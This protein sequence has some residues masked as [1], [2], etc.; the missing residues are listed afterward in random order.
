M[1]IVVAIKQVPER[2]APIHIASDGKWIDDAD[3]NYTINEPDAYALEEALQ[4]KERNGSGEVIVVCAGPERVQSTLREAL[5]KGADRA[6]HIEAD[7][8]TGLDTLGIAQILAD[9][10]KPESPDLILTGLQSDDLGLGQTGVVLAEVLNIPHAT[11]IMHVEP[12]GSGLKV[13]REL[14]DGWF[15]HVEM[16]LPALLTIQSGGNKL[17]YATLMGIKKAKTKELKTV[18]ASATSATPAITLERVYLP[19]KQK[20][21]EMLTGS[22]A[23]VA[24]KIVEKLKF[25]VRVI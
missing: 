5:A 21:T 17:R 4:L 7:D 13:K 2:D 8:L 12:T 11:I 22:P 1:K 10:I 20:K 6:I 3:L 19:E 25:E 14:E 18:A 23:E 15:Q 16:P 24:N 9:A